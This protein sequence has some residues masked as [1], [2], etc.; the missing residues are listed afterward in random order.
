M[1]PEVVACIP[2]K[3]LAK[4]KSRLGLPDTE[5]RLVAKR[6]LH[7]TVR[8]VLASSWVP[9]V[10]VVT[11]DAELADVATAAG[12]R[13]IDEG[14][15]HGLNAAVDTVRQAARF[16]APS[17]LVLTLVADLPHL[18][19]GEVDAL[20]VEALTHGGPV[21]VPDMAGTG[22]TGLLH[23]AES[24]GP[25]LFGPD[26]ARRHREAGYRLAGL[27]LLGLRDDLDD[28]AQVVRLPSVPG[29]D[30]LIQQQASWPAPASAVP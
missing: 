21:M 10:L 19:P 18:G 5:R 15:T 4:A 12:A 11:R 7:A 3:E 6:L 28:A 16:A 17:S 29:A 26:S 24:P 30:P 13:V 8:T 20:I 22:T 23:P 27:R 9:V 25:A 14:S 2:A 1:P